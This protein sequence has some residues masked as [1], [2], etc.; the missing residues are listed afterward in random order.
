MIGSWNIGT[1]ISKYIELAKILKK[2]YVNIAYVQEN[3]W[4]ESKARDAD[5]YKLCYYGVLK[6]KN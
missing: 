3:R 6:G 2:R 5:E 1:L 4:V